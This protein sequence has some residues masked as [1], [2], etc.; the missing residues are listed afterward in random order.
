MLRTI[1]DRLEEGLIALL[2][3]AMTLLTFS[4][5]I[6]RYV[7]Q[8]GFT[9]AL[10]ATEYMFAWLIFLGMSYGVKVGA[11]IGIDAAVKLLPRNGQRLIGILGALA[12]IAY[13]AILFIGGWN[14]MYRFYQLPIL[15]QDIPLPRWYFLT[16]LP[17]GFGLLALRFFFVFVRIL[18]GRQT[19]LGLADEA[20][21]ALKL[22]ASHAER[23]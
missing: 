15:S 4:Q 13:A 6:M 23:H 5:V 11:H 14:Y 1:V 2:L 19:G 16:V 17:L 21:D 18:Q 3:G 22:D 8:S 9:W 20:A 12:C 10:E 7:F